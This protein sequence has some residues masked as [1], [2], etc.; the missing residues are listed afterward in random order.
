MVDYKSTLFASGMD[1]QAGYA[2]QLIVRI[3]GK[4][5][6]QGNLTDSETESQ[7]I[8]LLDSF[9]ELVMES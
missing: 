1:P 2:G 4:I 6:D 8:Q 5:D 9:T 7:L 3:R